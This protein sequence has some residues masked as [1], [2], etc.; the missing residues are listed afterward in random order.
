MLLGHKNNFAFILNCRP[1]RPRCWMSKIRLRIFV[2]RL[3]V[4]NTALGETKLSKCK[5][6]IWCRTSITLMC[7]DK[8]YG[9]IM[10]LTFTEEPTQWPQYPT[11]DRFIKNAL[12]EIYANNNQV[13]SSTFCWCICWTQKTLIASTWYWLVM[14]RKTV[15]AHVMSFHSS[16]SSKRS[17][18]LLQLSRSLR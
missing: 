11:N 18:T 10:M 14:A 9:S 15:C 8:L 12:Q 6:A 2:F 3:F 4:P 17:K 13:L 1:R 7:H 5:N 16:A